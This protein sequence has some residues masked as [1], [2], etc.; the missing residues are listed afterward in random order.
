MRLRQVRNEYGETQE[1]AA[2][3]VNISLSMF[4][5]VEQGIKN[6][7]DPVKERIAEHYNLTVGYIFFDEPITY[8][9]KK[10]VTA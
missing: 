6:A 10:D 5:K 4:Q 2:I 3:A 1:E 7:S 8:S 9:N